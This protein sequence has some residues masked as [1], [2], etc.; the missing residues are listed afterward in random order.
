MKASNLN[1]WIWLFTGGHTH[2]VGHTFFSKLV[3]FC[4]KYCNFSLG[5]KVFRSN[6]SDF[7]MKQPL[8]QINSTYQSAWFRYDPEYTHGKSFM[9]CQL[10]VFS[11]EKIEVLYILDISELCQKI[12]M[13][14]FKAAS[15]M[16]HHAPPCT[17]N[18][19]P[20]HHQTKMHHH[21]KFQ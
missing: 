5:I 17:T 20:M 4:R 9:L 1:S 15:K 19:P 18:A 7:I 11:D 16:H 8:T 13:Q 2:Y 6:S 10:D 3:S 21:P 14:Q 12:Y